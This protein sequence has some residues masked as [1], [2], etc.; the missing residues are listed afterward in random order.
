MNQVAIRAELARRGLIVNG[1]FDVLKARLERDDTRGE[2]KGNLATMEEE[3]LR[4]GC[5]ILSINSRGTKDELIERIKTYNAYKRE[6]RDEEKAGWLNAGLPTPDDRLGKPT[7]RKIL[8]T[9]GSWVFSK[10]YARYLEEFER[11]KGT[12]EN[13]LTLRYWRSF[14]NPDI[15]PEKLW[16]IRHYDCRIGPSDDSDVQ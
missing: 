14:K 5:K 10:S 16:P 1:T 6:Q 11:E 7:Q 15:P 2:F 9:Q 13:A 12:T 4:D 8:G 3:Y